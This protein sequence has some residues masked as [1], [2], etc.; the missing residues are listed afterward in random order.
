MF[1]K[2]SAGPP[3][4]RAMTQF[5]SADFVPSGH[6]TCTGD[7]RYDSETE[8]ERKQQH[9]PTSAT[10]HQNTTSLYDKPLD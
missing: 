7:H 3:L 2:H 4:T 10:T 1:L 5:T 9:A 8:T 6:N